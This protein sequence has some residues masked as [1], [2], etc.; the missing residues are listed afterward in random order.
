MNREDPAIQTAIHELLAER[1]ALMQQV[2][3]LEFEIQV[4]QQAT[5]V[6]DLQR[7]RDAS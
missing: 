4:A 2:R 6:G 5:R 7:M 1:A 3:D